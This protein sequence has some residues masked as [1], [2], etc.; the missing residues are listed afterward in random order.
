[1]CRLVDVDEILDQL[2]IK[3]GIRMLL[4]VGVAVL[5]RHVAADGGIMFLGDLTVV[6]D[7]FTG[8]GE[9]AEAGEVEDCFAEEAGT[10]VGD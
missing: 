2:G 6:G 5:L 1:M 3:P 10:F 4:E 8:Y 7:P 9:E